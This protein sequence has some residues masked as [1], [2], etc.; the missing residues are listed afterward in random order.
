MVTKK[1][2]VDLCEFKQKKTKK[3]NN[4]KQIGGGF[5]LFGGGGKKVEVVV[6]K[7]LN[8]LFRETF[9]VIEV[10][11]HSPQSHFG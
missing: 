5:L 1:G 2:V 3:F 7:L 10:I 9:R 8:S 11:F 4:I 6:V